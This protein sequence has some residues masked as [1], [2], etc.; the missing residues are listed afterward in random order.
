[1]PRMNHGQGRGFGVIAL[2][3]VVAVVLWLAA[4]AISSTMGTAV[5][6]TDAPIVNRAKKPPPEGVRAPSRK[7]IDAS[8]RKTDQGTK[9]HSNQVKEALDQ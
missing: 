9:A 7:A 3:L 6:L 4:R 1:M 5:E 8:L 2:L